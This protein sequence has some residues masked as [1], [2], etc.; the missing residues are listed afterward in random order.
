MIVEKLG[1]NV[2]ILIQ[3]EVLVQ[4]LYMCF[5]FSR[6]TLSITYH[7]IRFE[8][9]FSFLLAIRVE[10]YYFDVAFYK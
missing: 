1:H 7:N 4:S 9:F 6:L 5:F 10:F 8:S 3:H 2:P